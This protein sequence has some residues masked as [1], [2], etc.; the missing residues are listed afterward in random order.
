MHLPKFILTVLMINILYLSA[1]NLEFNA[2]CKLAYQSIFKLK[3]NEGIQLLEKEKKNNASNYMPY[4][5]ENYADFLKLFVNDNKALLE[6]LAAKI[7]QD[8]S[9]ITNVT[10]YAEIGNANDVIVEYSKNYDITFT[11]MGIS[12]HGNKLMKAF[13]GSTAV[14][15]SKE[16]MTPLIIVP[17][18]ASYKK[19]ENI[20]FACD[21]D[22]HIESNTSLL[23]VKALNSILGATLNVLHVVP[24][25]H[26]LNFKESHIDSFVE[27]SLE[28]ATHKT[29]IITDNDISE[30]LLEFVE[31]HDIDAIIIEPKKHSFFHTLFYPSITNEVAFNS[32][33]PVITIHG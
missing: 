26:N 27:H 17:P 10:C 5:I 24:E 33:V 1:Q 23:Q 29:F 20:A 31:Y 22:E 19:I 3:L 18:D 16:T 25:N 9:T 7:K 21:Y 28:T 32:P 14:N 4:F 12:G 2:N 15:V 13:L 11:V 30:G 6:E 8:H